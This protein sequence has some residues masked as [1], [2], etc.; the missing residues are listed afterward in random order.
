MIFPTFSCAVCHQN[1]QGSLVR[2]GFGD[3]SAHNKKPLPGY[4]GAG[5]NQ[6]QTAQCR[7]MMST[8]GFDPSL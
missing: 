5:L 4:G 8:T 7:L 1:G 3:F 6:G 2:E